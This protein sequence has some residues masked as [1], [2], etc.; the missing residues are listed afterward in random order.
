MLQS[1][2]LVAELRLNTAENELSELE[3]LTIF[4]ILLSG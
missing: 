4:A 3:S 1:E 2:H